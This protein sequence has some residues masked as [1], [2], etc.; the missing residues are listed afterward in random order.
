MSIRIPKPFDRSRVKIKKD[1]NLGFEGDFLNSGARLLNQ[2]GTFNVSRTGKKSF[3]LYKILMQMSWTRFFFLLFMAYLIVNSFF[4]LL[5]SI[6]GAAGINGMNPG[7]WP[8]EFIQS[9]FLSIQT[10]TTVGYGKMNPESTPANLISV[11]NA[12]V[13]LMSFAL[14]TGL[15]FAKWSSPRHEILFSNKILVSNHNGEKALMVRFVNSMDNHIVDLTTQITMT[16][17][18]NIGSKKRRKF[19]QLELELDHIYMFPL[20][21]TLVHIIDNKSPLKGKN[22]EELGANNTEFLIIIKGYDV[23]Y[24]KAIHTARSYNCDDLVYGANYIPMYETT[25]DETILHLDQIDEI[26]NCELPD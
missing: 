3:N 21:W 1:A 20:N 18:T 11:A 25:D 8:E 22:M 15:F 5:Y 24:G 9:F 23:T 10:F 4:G 6:E 14:A 7:T 26:E 19:A 13:G 17:V 16:W 12:F 2:D